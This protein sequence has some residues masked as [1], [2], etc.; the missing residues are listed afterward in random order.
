MPKTRILICDDHTLFRE[1]V[2]AILVQEPSFEVIGEARDGKQAV[3][4]ARQLDPDVVLMDIAMPELSGFEATRRIRRGSKGVRIVILTMY[5]EEELVSRCLDAGASGYVLKDAPPAQL[6][7]AIQE[8]AKGGKYLSPGPLKKIVSQYVRRSR[9]VDTPYDRLSDREREVL[10]FLAEGRSAK[11]VAAQLKLSTK[12]VESHKYNLM[13]KL[14]V[15]DRS[16]LIR[17]AIRHKIILNDE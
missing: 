15:H 8:V 12:T 14:G 9:K 17:Y 16:G 2:K 13:R 1:G 5:D 6:I 10:I 3:E 11:E 7:Y 4:K